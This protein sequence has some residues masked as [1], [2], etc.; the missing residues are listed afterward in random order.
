MTFSEKIRRRIAV[1]IPAFQEERLLPVTLAG[2]PDWVDLIIVVDDASTDRTREVAQQFT[3]NLNAQRKSHVRVLS[4]KENQGVGR[5]IAVGYLEAWGAGAEVA[6]VMGA[7][8]QMDPEELMILLEALQGQTA[9]VKGNRMSHPEVK[10]RMP[11]IRYVGN[12]TLSTVTGWLMGARW[13]SDAQCGYTALDLR[14]LPYIELAHLYPRY[15][16]PNDL[17]LRLNEVGARVKQVDVTPIYGDEISKL[18]IPRVILPLAGVLVRGAWRR[19][20]GLRYL[21]RNK[22]NVKHQ[23][24]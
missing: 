17:L 10:S 20:F 23:I 16:F 6:I 11:W 5:A 22:H 15:G 7:D 13:L 18:S 9:Y 14:Y 12:R 24:K 21:G 8:A 3:Q 2:I 4:L 19:K 1:I